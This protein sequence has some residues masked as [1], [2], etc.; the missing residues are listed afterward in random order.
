MI[1]YRF[2]K[3]TGE[4]AGQHEAR[5]DPREPGRY[6]IPGGA[7]EQEPPAFDAGQVAVFDGTGWQVE[8]DHRGEVW[9][10]VRRKVEIKEIGPV[11][12]GLLAEPEPLPEPTR[13]EKIARELAPTEDP[14]DLARKLEDI[15][16]HLANGTPLPVNDSA[17][18]PYAVEWM[19]KRQTERG[20]F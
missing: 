4:Y 1:I 15:V 3:R 20:R 8:E 10:D 2:D 17:G 18:K 7:T 14:A 16:N 13:D 5:E 9:Y 12:D 11:P 19:E 6:L